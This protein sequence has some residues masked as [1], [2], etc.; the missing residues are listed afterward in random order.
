M[1]HTLLAAN[2]ILGIAT[3]T[4][5]LVRKAQIHQNY[6]AA[7]IG[8]TDPIAAASVAALQAKLQTA[9]ASPATAH[10]MALGSIYQS[11]QQQASLMAYVD[12]FRLLGYLALL[13]VPFILLFQGVRKP[14]G[15]AISI[16]E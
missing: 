14:S 5:L 12:G 11:L 3:A 7:H 13:C 10:A 1:K 16:E 8:A 4:A 15:R 9:G 2:A 6:L